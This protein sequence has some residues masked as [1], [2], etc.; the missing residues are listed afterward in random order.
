M[1]SVFTLTLYYQASDIKCDWSAAC[2]YDLTKQG[3]LHAKGALPGASFDFV[4]VTCLCMQ[5]P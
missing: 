4:S 3:V 1:F 5:I 2:H